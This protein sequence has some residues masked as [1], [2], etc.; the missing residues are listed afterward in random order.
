MNSPLKVGITG[1]IGS[2]KSTIRQIF[3]V[4]GIPTYDADSRAKWLMENDPELIANIRNAFGN[5]SYSSGKLNRAY[6]ADRVFSN[7]SEIETLNG[8]VHPAVGHD[9]NE[10]CANQ[11]SVYVLKEAALLIE[12][13]SYKELDYLVLVISPEELRVERI[14]Q[15]DPNRTRSDVEKI[16]RNQLSDSEKEKYAD[17]M[18]INDESS[19][20]TPEVLKIHGTL[21]KKK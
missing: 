16:I 7:K 2:G 14:L 11:R 20:V 4:L 10:W 1:G 5:Q 21:T 9:F 6:L 13:G 18:I 15:R 17:F 8:L 3:S 19:L 12:S